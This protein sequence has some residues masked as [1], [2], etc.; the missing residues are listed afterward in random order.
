MLGAGAS[1]DAGYPMAEGLLAAFSE[2]VPN[3]GLERHRGLL[4]RLWALCEGAINREQPVLPA[5]Q[6]PPPRPH[7]E[8]FF[9]F[10]D[11][12]MRPRV[13]TVAGPEYQIDDTERRF[14]RELREAALTACYAALMPTDQRTSA[15]YL[16]PLTHLPGPSGSPPTVMTLNFDVAFERALGER[17]IRFDDG[18]TSVETEDAPPPPGWTDQPNLLSFWHAGHRGTYHFADAPRGESVRL[19]KLHGSLGWYA[20]E[21]GR[22]A[23]GS[24][25]MERYDVPFLQFRVPYDWLWTDARSAVPRDLVNG[26]AWARH[27]GIEGLTGKAGVVW[28]RPQMVFARQLK[29]H[30]DPVSVELLAAFARATVGAKA[31]LTVGYS[32]SDPHINDLVLAAVA[33]GAYLIDIAHDARDEARIHFWKSRFPTTHRVHGERL[34]LFGGGARSVLADNLVALPSG[35]EESLDVIDAILRDRLP[36]RAAIA[37]QAQTG[38]PQLSAVSGHTAA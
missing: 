10:L 13:Q 18:F 32:W 33:G 25:E 20:I 9:G 14:L 11:D 21:E 31:L 38:V 3:A 6:F 4:Q 23:P 2:A 24:A 5:S 12:V 7:L 34:F 16:I 22:G 27:K 28:L 26:V 35:E 29:T 17:G 37:T 19:L 30:P 36:A 1:A 8:T 15:D